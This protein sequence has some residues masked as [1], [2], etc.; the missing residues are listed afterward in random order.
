MFGVLRNHNRTLGY[1]DL[2]LI[3]TISQDL[4]FPILCRWAVQSEVCPLVLRIGCCSKVRR[5]KPE[6]ANGWVA[7]ALAGRVAAAKGARACVTSPNEGAE[8]GRRRRRTR[9]GSRRRTTS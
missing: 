4:R 6:A 3:S 5:S 8:L 2:F 1:E 7:G 9:S